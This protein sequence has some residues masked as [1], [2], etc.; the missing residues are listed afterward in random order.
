MTRIVHIIKKHDIL[1]QSVKKVRKLFQRTNRLIAA[2]KNLHFSGLRKWSRRDKFTHVL[3]VKVEMKERGPF[4]LVLKRGRTHFSKCHMTKWL[5]DSWKL[6]PK[7]PK[8][9]TTMFSSPT[10]AYN[11]LDRTLLVW[12]IDITYF[13]S[14][15]PKYGEACGQKKVN[16]IVLLYNTHS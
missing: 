11:I 14:S 10:V 15:C 4:S 9:K 16:Y 8:T 3:V 5:C 12:I 1:S 13:W 7:L 2:V 6:G